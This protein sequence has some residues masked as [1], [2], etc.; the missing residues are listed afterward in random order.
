MKSSECF[1][2]KGT[3]T[4]MVTEQPAKLSRSFHLSKKEHEVQQY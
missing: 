2:K 4:D 3:H 1:A